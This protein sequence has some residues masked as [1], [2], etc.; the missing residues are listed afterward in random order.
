MKC[1][2]CNENMKQASIELFICF[3]HKYQVDYHKSTN[4]FISI[5]DEKYS[6]SRENGIDSI[7]VYFGE[8]PSVP[9]NGEV[10]P[11]N[12]DRILELLYFI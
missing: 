9:Y 8:D 12:I 7:D 5:I 11:E 2:Y 1:C 4:S 10:T 6:I 3:N